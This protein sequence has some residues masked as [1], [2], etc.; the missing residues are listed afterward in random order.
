M[1]RTSAG[2]ARR[3]FCRCGVLH[4][5]QAVLGRCLSGQYAVVLRKLLRCAEALPFGADD[6]HTAA[7]AHGSFADV[8]KQLAVQHADV[9]A[10]PGRP[11]RSC[12]QGAGSLLCRRRPAERAVLH[13]LARCARRLRPED[14]RMM[15]YSGQ[16]L[17]KE[18]WLACKQSCASARGSSGSVVLFAGWRAQARHSAAA[19]PD[20]HALAAS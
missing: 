3:E 4:Q 15:L 14:W 20:K 19:L 12:A 10:R 11:R 5:L 7:S 18:H 16:Y 8:L 9:E 2:G 17:L 6:L 13:M 1:L